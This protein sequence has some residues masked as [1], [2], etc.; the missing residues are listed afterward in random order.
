MKILITRF[1]KILALLLSVALFLFFMQ[2]YVFVYVDQNSERVHGF[3]QEETDSLD[4]VLMGASDV[5]TAFAPGLAYEKYGFT[6]YL[7]AFD[8]NPGS[9][10]KYQLKEILS[11]QNPQVILIEINGFLYPG[12][13]QSTEVRLR[14]FTDNIPFSLNK[15]D[16]IYHYDVEN[17]VEYLFP[18][19]KYHGDW[20]KGNK[21]LDTLRWRSTDGSKPALWKGVTACTLTR[22][23]DPSVLKEPDPSN[24]NVT[25]FAEDYLIDFLEFCKK[26]GITN[27]IFTRFPHRNYMA[28]TIKI[29]KI[30]YI[31]AQYGYTFWNLEEKIDEIGLDLNTDF[32]D[33]EHVNIYGQEKMTAYIGNYLIS[34]V[35]DEPI[36]QSEENTNHWSECIDAYKL[37]NAYARYMTE[38]G[39]ERWAA[40]EPYELTFYQQWLDSTDS[41]HIQ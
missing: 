12:D 14:L 36:P 10:Y 23:F 26:E 24:P 39:I 29:D 6:S 41:K 25:E 11:T 21:L 9:L 18:F 3:Y 8:A 31:L 37:F 16:A 5:N 13:Y 27:I 2:N 34:E 19:I 38:N 7:Y 22:P 1:L 40:E 35:L 30:K 15:L 20:I 33:E 32:Y 4:V 28:H 17:K